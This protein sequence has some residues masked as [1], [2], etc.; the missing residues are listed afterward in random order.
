[1]GRAGRDSM[2]IT[3]EALTAFATQIF[4]SLGASE[5]RA[6]ITAEH[7]VVANLKG[8]DS[9]GV[10]MIPSYV[11]GA[12]NGYLQVNNDAVVAQDK[13]VAL[14]IDGQMGFGQVVGRQATEMGI[15]RARQTGMVCVACRDCHHLGRIGSYGEQAAAAGFVSIHFANVVGHP[16]Y[17]S[18]WGGRDKVMQ[19]NP[20]CC[21]VPTD[22]EP[23]VLDMATS[24]IALGKVRV[25]RMKGVPVPEGSLFDA[26][27]V[28]TTDAEA[29]EHGGSLA[30][31]GRHKGYGLGLVCELL[32]GALAGEWTMQDVS[33]QKDA[34]INHML[35]FIIDPDLF[36][37]VEGFRREVEGMAASIR[38]C[39][40][41]AGNDKV[42][43]PGEPERETM[44]ERLANGIPIDDQSWKT[45]CTAAEKAGMNPA[46]FPS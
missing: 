29:L 27:G 35:E 15:E 8:H 34:V 40:P 31:F 38:A 10:G 14:L 6:L 46:D 42:R 20:F 26:Q 28:P 32:G 45:I 12:R 16:P 2:L 39:E 3:S 23:I 5:G 30:P 25:A 21:A 18:P 36:G 9:H 19:T 4:T 24:A 37:G 1:I 22:D 7:L 13:G 11:N 17:V 43:L 41:A 33:K 44:A